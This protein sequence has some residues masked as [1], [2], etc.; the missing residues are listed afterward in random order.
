MVRQLILGAAGT[1]VALVL[2][3]PVP[4]PAGEVNCKFVLKNLSI[5]R[6]P[7]EVAETMMISVEQIEKCQAEAA[8]Q[9]A[10]EGQAGGGA[11]AEKQAAPSH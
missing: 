10:A 11:G 4:A 2:A 1:V 3:G 7:E 9:K 5:G 6:T 8:A